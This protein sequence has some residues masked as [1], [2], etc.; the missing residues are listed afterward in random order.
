M[1]TITTN[2]LFEGVNLQGVSPREINK[3][4]ELYEYLT[5]AK[6]RADF[7]NE[8][9]E[10]QLDEGILSG[11]LGGLTGA[12]LGPAL[13]RAFCSALGINPD[14]TLGKLITSRLVLCAVGAQLGFNM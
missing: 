9:M 12:T 2:Q 6:E 3:A 8:S 14:G 13:G 1:A 4:K 11:L 7:L 10:S 5:N